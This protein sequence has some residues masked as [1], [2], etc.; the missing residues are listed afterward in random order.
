MRTAPLALL[1]A[2]ICSLAV[3][4]TAPAA[5]PPAPSPPGGIFIPRNGGYE[6][7]KGKARLFIDTQKGGALAL[8]DGVW[9]KLGPATRLELVFGIRP[10]QGT[11]GAGTPAEVRQAFDKS[12]EVLF[13]EE[14]N[15]RIGV[16]VKFKL[17]DTSN[18]YHGH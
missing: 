4:S 3:V 17:Y 12:P 13:L 15:D 16:R 9:P 8:V 6:G 18:T 10:A 1:C 14:G 2:S 7:H 5:P 11:A